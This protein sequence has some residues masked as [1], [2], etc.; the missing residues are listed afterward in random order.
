[1]LLSML[2]A[3]TESAL[4]A[5]H[6]SRADHKV[7]WMSDGGCFVSLDGHESDVG[8]QKVSVIVR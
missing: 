5:H 1:M 4:L 6:F 8:L 7:R 3:S 2:D